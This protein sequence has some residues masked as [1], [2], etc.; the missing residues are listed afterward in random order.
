MPT[1]TKTNKQTLFYNAKLIRTHQYKDPP[2]I[3]ESPCPRKQEGVDL[4]SVGAIPERPNLCALGHWM[5]GM[6]DMYVEIW[7]LLSFQGWLSQA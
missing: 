6:N 5:L 4:S 2:V 7:V 3:P 1:A